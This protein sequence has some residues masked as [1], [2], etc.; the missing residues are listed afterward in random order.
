MASESDAVVDDAAEVEKLYELGERLNEAKDK[1]Q[2]ASDY[3]GIIM[4]VQGK[5]MKA[6]Q[7][8]AQLIPRFFK[9]FPGLARKAVTAQFDLVEEEDLAIRVQ[10]IRGLPLLCKDIPEHVS[11]IVDVLGQLLTVEENVERDAVHK[12]IV[13]LLRQDAKDHG[14]QYFPVWS[15]L[16]AMYLAGPVPAPSTGWH[17]SLTALFKHVEIG[18]ELVREKVICFLR[19]KVFPLKA[20]LFKPQVEMERHVTDL[21][22]KVSFLH[23]NCN[24]ILTCMLEFFLDNYSV[25][26]QFY[27]ITGQK[28]SNKEVVSQSLQD[29]TGAEFKS[30]MDFLRSFSIFG[31]GAPPEHIQELLEIIED[32][33]DL[34]AQFIVS[35]IDHIDRLISCMYMGLP[36]FMRG[37]SSSKFLNY[38]NK[39]IL[40]VFDKTPNSTNSLCGYKIVTGQPSDRLGED[41]SDSYK[42]FTERLN[43][44]EEIAGA[45]MKKLTQRMAEHKKAMSTVK[46]EEEKAKIK[47]EQQ[48]T[49][50]GLRICNNILAMAQP[51]HAKAPSFI[52]DHKMNL[53]WKEPVTPSPASSTAAGLNSMEEIAGAAMK[54]LTQRMAEHKKAMSTVKT[55]EEK[56]KIKMEQQKTTSGLR[57]CNN[58]L[59]MAQPLHAK[60]PSF[61]GDHK[62]N[63]S[64]KEPVTPSPASSTAAGVKRNTASINDSSTNSNKKGRGGVMQSQLVNGALEGLSWGGRNNGR[65]RGW[66]GRGRGRGYR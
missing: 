6:K 28:C 49:T 23:Y 62:M 60:A 55:E 50:S 43:S 51:L 19:D 61:I 20:E 3:E 32:Q 35:D 9:F 48:K 24:S 22:K 44:M 18:M 33:A 12:A 41:F 8:A 66:R 2:H 57:I 34:D 27:F 30:F 52:G 36:F 63:L 15:V 53:S 42:D 13:S 25:S 65:G 21:V 38:F 14:F 64:W 1:S 47:M 31:D 40:P 54:K 10:A 17:A 46:T 16:V 56:A 11:K 7:L 37:A 39:H 29:V 26:C 59:A 45:A 5:S 58:I 4:A